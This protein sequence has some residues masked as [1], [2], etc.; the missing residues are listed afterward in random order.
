VK[1]VVIL[2]RFEVRSG[3]NLSTLIYA[4]PAMAARLISSAI[5]LGQVE[6]SEELGS[7]PGFCF[8][9]RQR[10]GDKVTNN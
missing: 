7:W 2:L 9:G 8:L 4:A 6:G 10:G 3:S 5:F 1:I